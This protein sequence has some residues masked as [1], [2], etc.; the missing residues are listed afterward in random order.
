MHASI[1]A[2]LLVTSLSIDAFVSSFAYGASKIKIPLK[3]IMI[4]NIVGS[5]ILGVSLF[6]GVIFRPFINESMAYTISFGILFTLG[7]TKIFDSTVKTLI[8]KYSNIDKEVK[9]SMFDLQFILNV[10]ANPE[11]AD[12][13]KSRIV[14][15][16][17]AVYLA[18][19]LALDSFAVGFGAGLSDVNAMQIV[20]FSLITDMIAIILGCYIGNKIAEKV[21]LNLSWISGLILITLAFT[22]L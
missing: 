6:L 12:V 3:S 19:A 14:S 8:T 15:P 1:E 10:Y 5:I 20:G 22:K 4:I 2:L 9:F 11:R 16:K 13:D 21:S 7:I 17:E 18:I